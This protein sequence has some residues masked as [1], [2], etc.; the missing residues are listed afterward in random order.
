MFDWKNIL[1]TQMHFEELRQEAEQDRLARLAADQEAFRDR[2]LTYIG[3]WIGFWL[4][5]IG[6][7]LQKFNRPVASSASGI[8]PLGLR[9]SNC[10]CG[11]IC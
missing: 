3:W 9:S 5:E 2:S 7:R 8:S 4:V 10:D 1:S 6:C 11:C